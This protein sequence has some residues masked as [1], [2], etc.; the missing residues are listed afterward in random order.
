[1]WVAEAAV[2]IRAGAAA[3]LRVAVRL[4]PAQAAAARAE[5]EQTAQPEHP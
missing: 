4:G 3:T 1:V 2:G 5:P